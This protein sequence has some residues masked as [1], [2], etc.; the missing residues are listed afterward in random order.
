M[1]YKYEV[2]DLVDYYG[3]LPFKNLLGPVKHNW[4]IITDRYINDYFN[5]PAYCIW[6][7]N[8]SPIINVRES[9]DYLN[10]L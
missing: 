5:E 6:F 8:C 1:K 9:S 7:P 4:G 2:G 10:P 3:R